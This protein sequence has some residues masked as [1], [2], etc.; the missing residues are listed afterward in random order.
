MLAPVPAAGQTNPLVRIGMLDGP[1]EYTFGRVGGVAVFRD[2]RVL[3]LDALARA[4][5]VYTPEGE[6]LFSF[7]SEGQGPGELQSPTSPVVTEDEILV[8]DQGLRRLV[9]YSLAG[10]HVETRAFATDVT[11]FSRLRALRFEQWIGADAQ[12][13]VAEARA[14]VGNDVDPDDLGRRALLFL[15]ERGIDTVEVLRRGD[16]WWYDVDGGSFGPVPGSGLAADLWTVSGDSLVV[17]VDAVIGS[18]RWMAVRPGHL[19]TVHVRDLE[20]APGPRRAELANLDSIRRAVAGMVGEIDFAIPDL[21]PHFDQVLVAVSGEVWLRHRDGAPDAPRSYL[22][23]T[24]DSA[25]AREVTMPAGFSPVVIGPERIW[26]VSVDELD[27]M[28]VHAYG[29]P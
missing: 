16:A 1:P 7:G 2:G 27:V 3:V 28:Y 26:G 14:L 25:P 11:A 23:V 24:S 21:S 22:V 19:E 5:R 20:L 13:P 8:Y 12:L 4:L 10:E 29:V 18:V 6:H 15:H 9:R 17:T